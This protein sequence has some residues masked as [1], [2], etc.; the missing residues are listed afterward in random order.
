MSVAA[1]TKVLD[2]MDRIEVSCRE[3]G[4]FLYAVSN[5]GLRRAYL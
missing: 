3:P 2:E 1:A 4:P 5:T